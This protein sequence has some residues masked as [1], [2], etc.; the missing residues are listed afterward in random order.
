LGREVE[1]QTGKRDAL[2][3][4]LELKT[5]EKRQLADAEAQLEAAAA[6]L[7]LAEVAVESA[8]LKLDRMTV[9]APVGGRVL[10]LVAR[11]GTRLMGL[12]SG[13]AQDASTVVTL[14]DPARL[15]IRADVRLDDVP[16]VVPGQSVRIETPAAPTGSV[17]GEVL[18]LTSQADIQKNTL[19]AKVA[20]TNPPPT[21]R[22]D[23]LVQATFLAP[24]S[25][26]P[27]ESGRTAL[28][29]M[30]PRALV[31]S[32]DGGPRVWIAD[33]AAGVARVRPVKIGLA[34]GD[35]IEVTEGLTVADRIIAGG[36]DGLR[37]GQRI[38]ITGEE[39]PPAANVQTHNTPT[40]LPQ[41]ATNNKAGH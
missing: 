41:P 23:M 3:Q 38:T 2:R 28:R 8:T 11:P 9:R 16:R 35:W 12:T 26:S 4:R 37:D 14:Y 39:A 33:Q 34:A 40:R 18:F 30:A 31:D 21:L 5:E 15:Q 6:R 25:A 1:A 36:R 17:A 24:P 22:P 13:T 27:T 20:L 19:Q 10:A 29:I 32:G 7:Q